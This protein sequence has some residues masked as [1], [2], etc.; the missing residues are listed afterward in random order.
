[1]ADDIE[2]PDRGY[3]TGDARAV[4]PRPARRR[5]WLWAVGLLVVVPAAVFAA[6][7]AIA[8]NVSYSLGERAGIIQKFSR[9]G[10]LCKTWEGELVMATIPGAVPEKF[11]FTVR[12]DSVA[13]AIN[14]LYRQGLRTSIRYAEHRGVPTSC[15]GETS[16]F[17]QGAEQIGGPVTGALPTARPAVP[18]ATAPP[19]A[20]A[21]ASTPTPGVPQ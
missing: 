6:W 10:W 5:W 2:Y 20:P 11:N 16:Y 21:P 14:A 3:N 13:A 1:M 7:S 12:S 19:A 18:A 4:A 15:F 9:K 8:L 17:V